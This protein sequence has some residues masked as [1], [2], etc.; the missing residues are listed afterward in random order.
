MA[1]PT[2]GP[3]DVS[4]TVERE[5]YEV[6]SNNGDPYRRNKNATSLYSFTL[7]Y[8]FYSAADWDDLI[9]HYEDNA[10]NTFSLAVPYKFPAPTLTVWYDGKPTSKRPNN[11]AWDVTVKLMAVVSV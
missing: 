4:H 5:V 1:Y 6:K 8:V 11:K 10:A 3:S 2:K 9:E 7:K